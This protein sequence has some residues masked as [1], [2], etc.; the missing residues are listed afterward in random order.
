[1]FKIH[2]DE[3]FAEWYE[4]ASEEERQYNSVWKF[5]LAMILT[6]VILFI[7]LRGQMESTSTTYEVQG[8]AKGAVQVVDRA[9]GVYTELRDPDLV[10]QALTGKIKRGD[11]IYR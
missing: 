1:M 10:K 5:C 6:S 2:H 7:G 3:E 8:V 4:N 11:I 9:T